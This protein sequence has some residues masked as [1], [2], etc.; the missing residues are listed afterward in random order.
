MYF[1]KTPAWL[2]KLFPDIL[3]SMGS[4]N[5]SIYL[6]F[7]DGP[8][9]ESTPWVLNQLDSFKA[10]ATFFMVGENIT[11]NISLYNEVMKGG[12]TLGNH[13]YNH[14]NGWRTTGKSY[15]E[16]VRK[17]DQVLGES[18]RNL[19]RPPYGKLKWHQYKRLKYTYKIVMWDV[20]S[21]DFS[22]II[23]PEDCLNRT[24]AATRHGSIVVFHDSVKSL[25]NLQ[26][27]LPR[28]L[29]HFSNLGFTFKAI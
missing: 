26:Y 10:K 3:W 29:E 23:T 13:T 14:L 18:A 6:T 25:R 16:N 5:K 20:L 9:P 19:F 8:V 4:D 11:K 7:D 28:Y 1:H 22:T 2:F 17:A 24:I 12:H 27:V 21:A 15:L